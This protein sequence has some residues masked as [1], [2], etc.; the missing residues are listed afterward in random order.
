MRTG[1]LGGQ[2]DGPESAW[3]RGASW[4]LYGMTL[5]YAYTGRIEFIECAKR[6]AR[7]ILSNLPEDLVPYWD[8]KLDSAEGAPRDSSA[9]AIAASGLLEL[10][11]HCHGSEADQLR[12]AGELI[13]HSLY[14][15]YGAWQDPGQ[16]GLLLHG[17]R[18][19]PRGL[20]TDHPL[21]YG[22]YFFVEAL[23]KLRGR[24]DLFW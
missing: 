13:A 14:V 3:A 17:V 9:A 11:R 12:E 16:E 6:T 22:D 7:F 24:I 8:Y 15:H 20:H 23:L 2:G 18:N 1:A 10:A 4:A 21:I 5:S 19:C